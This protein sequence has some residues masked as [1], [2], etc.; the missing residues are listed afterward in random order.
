MINHLNQFYGIPQV[1]FVLGGPGSG[2]GTQCEYINKTFDYLHISTGDLLREEVKKNNKYYAEDI[3]IIKD[4][5]MKG[6]IVPISIV[7]RVIR[8]K[9]QS[10][11][12]QG[13]SRIALDGFPSNIDNIDGWQLDIGQNI[14][15]KGL[16]YFECKEETMKKRCLE[17][18]KIEKREDDNEASI[19][20][21]I[22]VFKKETTPVIAMFE[23]HNKVFKVNSEGSVTD[24][25]KLVNNVFTDNL[26]E[27]PGS[28]P[29][30]MFVI[31][32]PGSGKGTQC[33]YM[34]KKYGAVHLSTGDCLR[35]EINSKS[36]DAEIIQLHINQGILVPQQIVIRVLRKKMIQCVKNGSKKFVIDGFPATMDNLDHWTR[37]MSNSVILSGVLYLKCS[38]E[39]LKK[40]CLERGKATGRSDDNE[41][42]IKTRIEVFKKETEPVMQRFKALKQLFEYIYI[43]IIIY[44][45]NVERQIA[46][47]QKDI[48]MI[49]SAQM[50]GFIGPKPQKRKSFG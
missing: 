4:C 18:G 29:T 28:K 8:Q 49:F 10:L 36:E 1:L 38:D 31:G 20:A 39:I 46:D 12:R 42:S 3:A 5:M 21:R 11:S 30:V 14:H 48:D 15:I 44:R 27:F 41:A 13:K 19:K 43:Y 47:I 33:E 17:R 32:G 40:R 22:E 16:L 50:S 25:N 7:I 26:F 35:D 2:K 6:L 45:I 24:V 9:L 34:A 23:S 37:N